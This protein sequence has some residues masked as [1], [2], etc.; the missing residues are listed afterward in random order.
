[1]SHQPVSIETHRE[2]FQESIKRHNKMGTPRHHSSKKRTVIITLVAMLLL[3]ATAASA[4]AYMWYQGPERIVMNAILNTVNA[5]TIGFDGNI[6][7]QNTKVAI[8]GRMIDDKV[9]VAANGSTVI[10]NQPVN[11]N[12]DIAMFA[13]DTY[14]KSD[15]LDVLADAA[16]GTSGNAVVTQ[17]VATL[18]QKV[19]GRWVELDSNSSTLLSGGDQSS[20]CLIDFFQKVSASQASRLQVVDLYRQNPFIH[21]LQQSKDSQTG[22]YDL[23]ID[24]PKF[25]AFKAALK[26][27]ELHQSMV[28][29]TN[30]TPILTE[31]EAVQ[32]TLEVTIDMHHMRVSSLTI[33]DLTK[34]A[35][36]TVGL[37]Y[38]DIAAIQRP[39]DALVLS[40]L[41][42]EALRSVVAGQLQQL[43]RP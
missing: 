9:T 1:M 18:K 33:N 20:G 43:L 13:G 39:T 23:S 30:D 2:A 38:D 22:V 25:V 34:R 32:L 42:A 15:Q 21:T 26:K 35:T 14:I 8:S 41:R 5:P 12:A 29:C 36:I 40:E 4:Y 3:L 6:V 7:A 16:L 11:L 24:L 28:S 10:R 31:D 17:S 19:N 37:S 27:T